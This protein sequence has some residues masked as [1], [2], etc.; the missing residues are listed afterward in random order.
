MAGNLLVVSAASTG[1]KKIQLKPG[2]KC[3]R[4]LSLHDYTV[5]GDTI[6][7]PMKYGEVLVLEMEN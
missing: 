7:V 3:R 4:V 2:M 6:T 1:V 5:E